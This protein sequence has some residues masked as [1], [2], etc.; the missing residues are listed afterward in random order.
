[1]CV[2]LI[3]CRPV[4]TPQRDA[5]SDVIGH[6]SHYNEA[7][8]AILAFQAQTLNKSLDLPSPLNYGKVQF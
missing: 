7:I 6:G 1:M 3:V 8:E 5:S 4:M 2:I